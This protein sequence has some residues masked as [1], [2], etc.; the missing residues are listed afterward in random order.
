MLT[1]N[2]CEGLSSSAALLFFLLV[3]YAVCNTSLF[4]RHWPNLICAIWRG[5]FST[6]AIIVVS[7]LLLFIL[8]PLVLSEGV[9][10]KAMM[11]VITTGLFVGIVGALHSYR[12]IGTWFPTLPL[13]LLIGVYAL[14]IL[15]IGFSYL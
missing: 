6:K 15:S 8:F 13:S 7:V 1:G 3:L 14:L 9:S 2:F 12:L 11:G 4:T 10:W 5:R